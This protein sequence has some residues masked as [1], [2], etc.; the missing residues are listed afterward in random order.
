MSRV[1]LAVTVT[2]VSLAAWAAGC[3]AGLLFAPASGAEFRRRLSWKARDDWKHIARSCDA[4]FDRAA[5][6]A[7]NAVQA[8]VSDVRETLT[9]LAHRS[10]STH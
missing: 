10:A 4:V 3:A 1:G 9:S 8:T 6:R 2:A 5:G 7:R